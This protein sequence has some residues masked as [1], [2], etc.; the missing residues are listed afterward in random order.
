MNDKKSTK[1]LRY[2]YIEILFFTF[3]T[4]S[5]VTMPAIAIT[6]ITGYIF[7]N[8]LYKLTPLICKSSIFISLACIFFI[9]CIIWLDY[10]FFR[11]SK[12]LKVAI[13]ISLLAL[14]IST[15]SW[16]MIDMMLHAT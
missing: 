12:L 13:S 4:L 15:F 11:K 3:S 6:M 10:E 5:L 2:S 9:L 1:Q 16:L 14:P 8:T 7:S